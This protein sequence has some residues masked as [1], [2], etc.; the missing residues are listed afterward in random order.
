VYT[1]KIQ[2]TVRCSGRYGIP[3]KRT[4]YK[5]LVLG[6]RSLIKNI[7]QTAVIELSG[8]QFGLKS[9]S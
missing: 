5:L 3:L 9:Y 6:H 4:I 8:V 1:E 7:T 2:V